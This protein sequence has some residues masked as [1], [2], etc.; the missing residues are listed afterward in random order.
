M[1]RHVSTSSTN[2]KQ[3][4]G[5]WAHYYAYSENGISRVSGTCSF[6]ECMCVCVMALS[7]IQ[8]H[9]KHKQTHTNVT[10]ICNHF[11]CFFIDQFSHYFFFF[12]ASTWHSSNFG[13]WASVRWKTK[14]RGS[15]AITFNLF[16]LRLSI[17]PVC[18]ISFYLVCY[19]VSSCIG[20]C[21]GW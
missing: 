2:I 5:L 20:V 18:A 16:R 9:I 17:R 1:V 13:R 4:S 15:N 8:N 19:I 7:F 3:P 21:D 12:R 14:A 11:N 10:S 6:D